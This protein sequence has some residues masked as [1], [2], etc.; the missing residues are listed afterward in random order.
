MTFP[1]RKFH[2]YSPPGTDSPRAKANAVL[3]LVGARSL[4]NVTAQSLAH[5]Y[6]LKPATAEQLLWQEVQRRAK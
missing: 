3:F 5:T 2:S 6:R 4:D 1:R